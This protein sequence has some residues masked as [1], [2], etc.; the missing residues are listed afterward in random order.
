MDLD[1]KSFYE[2][3]KKIQS[4]P[5]SHAIFWASYHKTIG[6]KD[7]FL[8]LFFMILITNIST[9]SNIML[10]LLVVGIISR[11]IGKLLL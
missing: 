10:L 6:D 4:N 11:Y 8:K 1:N 5:I 3:Y 9:I 7:S 2:E